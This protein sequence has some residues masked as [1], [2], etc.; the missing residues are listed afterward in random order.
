MAMQQRLYLKI[1]LAVLASIVIFAVAT[2]LLWRTLDDREERSG[3]RFDVM[4]QLMENAM[5][6]ASLPAE[7]QQAALERLTH[8]LRLNAIVLAPSGQVLAQVGDE[9]Y[10]QAGRQHK[11]VPPTMVLH[12]ADGRVA[13]VR[14]PLPLAD[15]TAQQQQAREHQ[16]RRRPV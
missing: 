13:Y 16:R 14:P 2:A 12:L 11:D 1:Y 9:G 4:M 10:A 15:A 6:D 3:G 5:P 8:N 7:Q